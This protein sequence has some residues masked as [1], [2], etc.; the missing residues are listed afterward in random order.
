MTSV[1]DAREC[2]SGTDRLRARFETDIRFDQ[3]LR[4]FS[5]ECAEASIA[6]AVLLCNAVYQRAM[7]FLSRC[8]FSVTSS[9][10]RT[11]SRFRS[12]TIEAL[13]E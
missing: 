8:G 7:M 4:G 12:V 5:A 11:R 3:D 2:A 10:T 1:Q 9:G 13:R 6:D